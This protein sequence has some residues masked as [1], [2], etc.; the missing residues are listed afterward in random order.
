V[1]TDEIGNRK[2]AESGNKTE[3]LALRAIRFIYLLPG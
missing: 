1:G 3:G 2:A